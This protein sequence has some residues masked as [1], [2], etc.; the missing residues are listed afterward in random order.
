MV[1]GHSE[2]ATMQVLLVLLAGELFT[3][4]G[5]VE[6]LFAV[7]VALGQGRAGVPNEK[8]RA[9]QDAS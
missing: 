4:C 1:G 5:A 3:V 6:N 9:V 2:I 8:P 7:D